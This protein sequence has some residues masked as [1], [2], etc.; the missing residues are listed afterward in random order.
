[1]LQNASST[2]LEGEGGIGAGGTA[3]VEEGVCDD[4]VTLAGE[5]VVVEGAV[6]VEEAAVV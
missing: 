1:L 3:V 4:V 5:A 6:V 2:I